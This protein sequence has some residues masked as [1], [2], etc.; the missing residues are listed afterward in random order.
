MIKNITS[1]DIKNAVLKNNITAW[2]PYR[3]SICDEPYGY[4]FYNGIVTFDGA[5]GC[6]TIFGE[7]LSSYDE[8][9]KLYN[10]NK[11]N[12]FGEEI[13]EYFKLDNN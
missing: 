1:D 10:D 12:K 8:I 4:Y 9:V 13:L 2:Y 6:G 7:R 5:C 11:N 3:C